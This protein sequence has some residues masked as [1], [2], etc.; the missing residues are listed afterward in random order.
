MSA[1]RRASKK[2]EIEESPLRRGTA[3]ISPRIKVAGFLQLSAMLKR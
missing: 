3:P 2:Q 1:P